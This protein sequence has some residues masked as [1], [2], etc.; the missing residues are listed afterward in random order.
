MHRSASQVL[1]GR[2]DECTVTI[3]DNDTGGDLKFASEYVSAKESAGRVVCTVVRVGGT[4]GTVGC[5][6]ATKVSSK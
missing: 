3:E 1:I 2:T 5:N 6:F 4:A